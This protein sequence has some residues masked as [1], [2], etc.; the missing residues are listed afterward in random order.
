MLK[1]P[2]IKNKKK[3]IHQSAP[4]SQGELIRTL[5]DMTFKE[6]SDT[7]QTPCKLLV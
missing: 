5:W 6:N 2:K 4:G 1:K 3:T 7:C